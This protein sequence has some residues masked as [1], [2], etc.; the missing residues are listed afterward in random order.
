MLTGGYI[1]S[2]QFLSL[3]PCKLFSLVMGRRSISG[4]TLAPPST[5]ATMLNFCARHKIAPVIETFKMADVNDAPDHLREGKARHR[6][7]LEN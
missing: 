1:S 7:V 4:P 2:E 3:S 5:V 6:V